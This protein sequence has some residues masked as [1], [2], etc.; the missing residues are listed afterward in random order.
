MHRF[1]ATFLPALFMAS[2][3]LSAPAASSMTLKITGIAHNKFIPERFAYCVPDGKGATRDGNNI[4][5]EIQ[6]SGAPEGTKSYALIMVDTEVP[7]SFENANKKDTVIAEDFPRQNFYHW[8][9]TDIPVNLFGFAEGAHSR[10]I[11]KGGKPVGHMQ[12]G[13]NGQNDYAKVFGGAGESGWG[14]YDGPCPPFNDMRLH[15][16][17]FIIYA[18]DVERLNLEG[19]FNGPQAEEAMKGHILA[20]GEV[21]GTYSNQPAV[22]KYYK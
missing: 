12:Y 14:G 18:L 10:E 17:H 9:L 22:A 21:V 16:Y 13:V 6:W 7:A 20:K 3:A 1:C 4:S 15:S 2:S 19:V 5:P 8:V 11:I